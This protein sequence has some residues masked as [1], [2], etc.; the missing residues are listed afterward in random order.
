M[1]AFAGKLAWLAFAFCW[2]V[3]RYRYARLARRNRKIEEH[4]RIYEIVL[5]TLAFAGYLGIPALYLGDLWLSFGDYPFQPIL[6]WAGVATNIASDM[7]V[8]AQS[9]RSRAQ[10]LDQARDPGKACIW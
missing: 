8:L 9:R 4:D 5:L 10:F 6:F 3:I 2:G 7:A 1:T